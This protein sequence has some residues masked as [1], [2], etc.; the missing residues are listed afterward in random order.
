MITNRV[1]GAYV[2]YKSPQAFYNA[3]LSGFKW[4]Y[5]F[6]LKDNL[7]NDVRDAGMAALYS[8]LW[9]LSLTGIT[10]VAVTGWDVSRGGGN[11]LAVQAQIRYEQQ[12]N[13]LLAS[14]TFG[15]LITQVFKKVGTVVRTDMQRTMVRGAMRTWQGT[16]ILG[17]CYGLSLIHKTMEDSGVFGSELTKNRDDFIARAPSPELKEFKNALPT[18]GNGKYGGE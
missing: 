12:R 16:G 14:T 6:S 9:P 13:A 18:S 8:H 10:K 5:Y 4:A 2:L 11:D 7:S 17:I 15:L 3:G 1:N